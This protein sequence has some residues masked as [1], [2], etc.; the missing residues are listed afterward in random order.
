MTV[1]TICLLVSALMILFT[2]VPVALAQAK[3]EH[4]YDNRNPRQQQARLAG[5]GAR[6]LAAH[7][8]MIEAFP[9]FA[10][11]LLLALTA[12]AHGQW[13]VILSIAFVVARIVYSIFYWMDIHALR[14][15]SWGIGFGASIALM[16]LP[17]IQI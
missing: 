15:L 2:K 12:G 16:A 14:S 3:Q 5:F 8:N 17:L 10:A 7:Q 11:G 13:V 4:G 9:V 1:P 6:A